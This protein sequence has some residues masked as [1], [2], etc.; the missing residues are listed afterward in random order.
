ML[1]HG[2]MSRRFAMKKIGWACILFAAIPLSA[3]AA[4]L[5]G[6]DIKLTTPLRVG[7]VDLPPGDY[8]LI[9]NGPGADIQITWLE[10]YS[11]VVATTRAS[12]IEAHNEMTIGRQRDPFWIE[13]RQQ[14]KFMVL[15]AIL[16]P[17]VKLVFGDVQTNGR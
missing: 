1:D 4:K 2:T 3:F 5:D 16:L 15:S 8:R 11:S 12:V 9:W 10:H 14:G 17:K 13:K 7:S 6:A